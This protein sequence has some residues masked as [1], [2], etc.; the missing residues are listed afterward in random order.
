MKM[1]R[2]WLPEMNDLH[3]YNQST[4]YFC[5]NDKQ[6]E[7]KI[8]GFLKLAGKCNFQVNEKKKFK[9]LKLLSGGVF[10]VRKVKMHDRRT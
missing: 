8:N 7:T 1:L 9:H 10:G 5:D 3:K 2:N 4:Q 6:S